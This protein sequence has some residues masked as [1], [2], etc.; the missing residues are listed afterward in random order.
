LSIYKNLALLRQQP[1]F[2]YGDFDYLLVTNHIFS[3]VR[4][5]QGKTSYI[6]AMN[7]SENDYTLNLHYGN[8]VP[9]DAKITYYFGKD[10]NESNQ[11][12]K[13]YEI[14]K[15]ITTTNIKL[16]A[17]NCLILEF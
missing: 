9:T 16:K 17:R 10:Q 11:L 1:S 6:V 13:E 12:S 15:I 14:G 2:I 7:L 3:F 4:K 5:S 8:H